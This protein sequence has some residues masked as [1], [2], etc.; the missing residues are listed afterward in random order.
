[1][2]FLRSLYSS[3]RDDELAAVPWQLEQKQMFLDQQF[4]F[5]HRHYV[6]NHPHADFLIVERDGEE[7]GRLYVD[8]SRDHWLI[9]EIGLLP[10]CRGKGTGT[11]LL[12][13]LLAQAE[14]SDAKAVLL[15]VE[16]NNLRAQALYRRLG[17]QVLDYGATHIRMERT[18]AEIS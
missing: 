14:R 2:L 5:Q 11:A 6:T 12:S 16:Q 4:L 1:M 13:A 18:F 17:F 9:A 7:I 15:H 8:C 10:Q 3:F